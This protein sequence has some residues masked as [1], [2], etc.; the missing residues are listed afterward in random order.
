[1]K[2]LLEDLKTDIETSFK[3]TNLSVLA[4]FYENINRY[5]DALDQWR[6]IGLSTKDRSNKKFHSEAIDETL[7]ILNKVKNNKQIFEYLKWI[8]SED[9][10]KGLELFKNLSEEVVTIDQMLYY[11]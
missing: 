11:F 9:K 6:K 4:K 2:T 7:N 5:N 3:E 10:D 8:I 1:M